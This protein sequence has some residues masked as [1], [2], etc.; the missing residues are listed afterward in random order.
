MPTYEYRCK[1]CGTEL[2]VV[3]SFT[4]DALTTCEA[5]GGELRKVF[6][7]VG[8]SFKGSGFYKTDSRN[9]SGKGSS[10]SSTAEGGSDTSSTRLGLGV[11][12]AVG[13]EGR[14]AGG[15]R[16][17]AKKADKQGG[18]GPRRGVVRLHQLASP[19]PPRFPGPAP[20]GRRRAHAP[21][22]VPAA[23]DLAASRPP[24]AGPAPAPPPPAGPRRSP[25]RW[26]WPS[27]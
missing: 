26:S 15:R 23:A 20:P 8:I 22:L 24:C 7:T 16:T 27:A 6:G 9:G 12:Q 2:E 14:Q 3:Q 25:W 11:R 21:D 18:Q 1:D 5:C 10:S 13:E 4:D 17:S 19:A